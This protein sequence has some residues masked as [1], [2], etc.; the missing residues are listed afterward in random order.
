MY[1]QEKGRGIQK[2]SLALGG[3][4]R[5]GMTCQGRLGKPLPDLGS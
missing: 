1:S 2:V 3:E 5:K 4:K